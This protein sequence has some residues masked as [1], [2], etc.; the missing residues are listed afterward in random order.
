VN[1]GKILICFHFNGTPNELEIIVLAL[2]VLKKGVTV[3]SVGC[4]IL[5]EKCT[6]LGQNIVCSR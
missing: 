6:K 2:I 5:G 3:I 1:C 4:V